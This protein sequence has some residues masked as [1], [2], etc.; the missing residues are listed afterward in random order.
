MPNA[1]AE[2]LALVLLASVLVFAVTRPRD[3]P[4]AVAAAPA[5]LLLCLTGVIGWDSAAQQI[6]GML[7]TILFL[8]GVLMLSHLCRSEGMFEAAGDLMSRRAN[9]R[10]CGRR[11]SRTTLSAASTGVPPDT[12]GGTRGGTCEEASNSAFE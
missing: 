12:A 4:E 11:Y 5:A 1:A 8:A 10:R 9:G 7:P 6:A 2:A 3:L